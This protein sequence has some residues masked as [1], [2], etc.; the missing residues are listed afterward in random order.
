MTVA[1]L[2][3]PEP[4]EPENELLE[5]DPNSLTLGE[6]EEIEDIT[7]RPVGAELG[8]GTPSMRTLLAVVFIM[9]RRKDPS[10]T[11]DDAR[12][13]NINTISLGAKQDPKAG[14]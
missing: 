1:A 13:L 9:K 3:T 2:P 14:G 11:L 6:L 4:E 8:R 5:I 12:K 7:G 10:Y